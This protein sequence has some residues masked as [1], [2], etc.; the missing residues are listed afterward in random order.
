M[1]TDKI[2]PFFVACV[3]IEG[4]CGHNLGMARLSVKKGMRFFAPEKKLVVTCVVFS[5][6]CSILPLLL[7]VVEGNML[8]KI[9]TDAIKLA[10]LFLVIGLVNQI[11]A[12]LSDFF[13]ELL[14]CRVEKQ[15]KLLVLRALS[16]IKI[17]SLGNTGAFTTR[18]N[19]DAGIV[20]SGYADVFASI[21]KIFSN[22]AFLIFVVVASPWLGLYTIVGLVL[23]FVVEFIRIKL[24]QKGKVRLLEQN[25]RADDVTN[26]M[27]VGAAESKQLGNEEFCLRKA[28]NEYERLKKVRFEQDQKQNALS[29]SALALSCILNLGFVFLSVMLMEEGLLLVSTFFV[30]YIYRT[31]AEKFLKDV[32]LIKYKLAEASLSAQR[33]CDVVDGNRKYLHQTFGDVEMKKVKGSLEVKNL[34]FHFNLKRP[35]IKNLNFEL[36]PHELVAIMGKSGVGKSTLLA[37]MAGEIRPVA[38]EIL[39]DEKDI[40]S[41]TKIS[42]EKSIAFVSSK[43]FFF[44]ESVKDNLLRANP[45]ASFDDLVAVCKLVH[46]HDE[47]ST[48][49]KGYDSE[50]SQ[51][52]VGFSTG[53]KQRLALA[54]AL[55][56]N[57]K[58]LLIDEPTQS[59]DEENKKLV[60]RAIRHISNK[61][62]VV[63]ATHDE[64]MALACDRVF[65]M[66]NGRLYKQKISPK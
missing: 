32:V 6:V 50:I 8:A 17:K 43:P 42:R 51:R 64:D 9:R 46:V 37:L 52:G 27:V 12:F 60:I 38:G 3:L 15:I 1:G 57:S 61:C 49:P 48:R 20:S 35:I 28:D 62:S 11:C 31:R 13:A 56:K 45:K 36:E 54:R 65:E 22:T 33:I 39:I 47:I 53:E 34:F 7:S 24:W 2:S 10:S 16:N 29:R 30:V 63:V 21:A 19:Q 26:E 23:V 5:V 18:I 25:E 55:L 40:N 59:L 66:K 41:L 14:A 4:F 58:I 44:T